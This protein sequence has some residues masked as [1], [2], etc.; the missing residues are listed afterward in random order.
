MIVDVAPFD[1]GVIGCVPL[2]GGDSR[3]GGFLRHGDH[4]TLR[5]DV[6]YDGTPQGRGAGLRTPV[7]VVVRRPPRLLQE[8]PSTPT[9]PLPRCTSKW[10]GGASKKRPS[11]PGAAPTAGGVLRATRRNGRPR[12]RGWRSVSGTSP[13]RSCSAMDRSAGTSSA[14]AAERGSVGRAD[15]D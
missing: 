6:S 9:C 10:P 15:G 11:G 13:P 14:T 5:D 2:S 7:T 8:A 4:L 3:G 1:V 12:R